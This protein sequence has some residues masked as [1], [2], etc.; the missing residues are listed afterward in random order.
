MAKPIKTNST[1]TP[2]LVKIIKVFGL[3]S[4]ALVIL[5]SFFND[6]RANNTGKDG[7]F[8]MSSS[9][10]IYFSNVRGINYER[11]FRTD[12]GMQIFRNKAFN[13]EDENPNLGLIL[14]LNPVKE[15]AYIYLEPINLDWPVSL[16]LKSA[17]GLESYSFENGNKADHLRYFE[18]LKPAVK[19]SELIELQTDEGWI[20]I[21]TSLKEKEAIKTILEDFKNLTQ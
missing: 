6:R 18:I 16:R 12:A 2:E 1:L 19:S 10:R 5:F 17:K 20:P 7:D 21:W 8:R 3:I 11:E 9:A 13:N 14:I 15:E 4:I